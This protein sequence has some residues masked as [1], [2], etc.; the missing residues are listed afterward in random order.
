MFDFVFFQDHS[1][2][3]K[4]PKV[5]DLSDLS[6]GVGLAVVISLYCPDEL[7]WTEIALGDPP[8]MADSLYNIQLV[9]R[10]CQSTPSFNPCHLSIEDFVYLH[11]S[12]KQNV[13]CF[14]ADLFNILEV[15]PIRP[16]KVPG[17]P[18]NQVIEVPDPGKRIT[19]TSDGRFSTIVFLTRNKTDRRRFSYITNSRKSK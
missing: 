3:P 4:F 14:M 11:A 7:A 18:K 6:D 2:T 13:I 19:S 9:Q 16:A 10:F 15:K 1:T 5:Q 17:V 8:S 12:I